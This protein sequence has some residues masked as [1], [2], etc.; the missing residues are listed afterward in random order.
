MSEEQIAVK[1]STIIK[2]VQSALNTAGKNN[3]EAAAM[4][5]LKQVAKM[6]KKK[7]AIAEIV[8]DQNPKSR[9]QCIQCAL[10]YIQKDNSENAAH[11]V[12]G[13]MDNNE[14]MPEGE[15]G[16]PTG[17]GYVGLENLIQ[18]M[19]YDGHTAF[20]ECYKTAYTHWLH[21]WY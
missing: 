1:P 6:S 7:R 20:L 13:D 10:K 21:N 18:L 8:I 9:I 2:C 3:S 11:S 12:Q 16:L 17:Y 15:D 14:Y 19:G 4:K 5:A